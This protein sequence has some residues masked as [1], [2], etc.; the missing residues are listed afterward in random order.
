MRFSD[1]DLVLYDIDGTLVDTGGAGMSALAEAAEQFFGAPSPALDLA[2]STDLG[3]VKNLLDHYGHS[4]SSIN[5]DEF[6]TLY[7]QRLEE[8][9]ASGDFAGFVH[10]G[11]AEHIETFVNQSAAIGLLTGNTSRGAAI[12]MRHFML[13]HHF[14][15]GAFGDDFAD[16]NLLGPVALKRASDLYGKNFTPKR[17]LVIGDTPKDIACA[18]AMG[19]SCL[20]V[21]TGQ[22]SVVSLHDHGATYVWQNLTIK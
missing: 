22:F 9:L 4:D 10:P 3:I 15:F 13:D 20:A 14:P 7:H 17:T 16:R 19:A 18:K 6:F 8:N 5:I 21:A 2:G 1:Y 12:K 11:V